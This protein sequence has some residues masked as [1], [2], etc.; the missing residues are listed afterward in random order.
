M[1]NPDLFNGKLVRLT[2]DDPEMVAKPYCEWARDTEYSRYLDSNPPFTFSEKKWK[3][4]MEKDMEKT[5]NYFFSIRSLDDNK[6]LGFVA[7]FDLHWQHG[8]TLVA[9][10]LGERETWGKGYGTDAMNVMLRYAFTELNL[11]RVTLIVFEYNQRGIRSYEKNE[12]VEEGRTRGAMLRDGKRWDF[13]WMGVM[14]EDWMK[15][16]RTTDV[17]TTG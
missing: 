11:R 5:D 8:D 13:I 14:R 9:I 4:W 3:E 2:A 15:L 17:V 1:S 6:L 10:A 7:L 12:F 16:Q